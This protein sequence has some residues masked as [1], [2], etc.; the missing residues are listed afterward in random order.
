VWLSE[1]EIEIYKGHAFWVLFISRMARIFVKCYVYKQSDIG[2][3]KFHCC[4]QQCLFPLGDGQHV[5]MGDSMMLDDAQTRGTCLFCRCL[6]VMCIK[7]HTDQRFLSFMYCLA[8]VLQETNVLH[9][10]KS[11]HILHTSCHN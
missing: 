1:S 8:V 9:L 11:L 2:P 5:C 7:T 10:L 3:E 4:Q 6:T